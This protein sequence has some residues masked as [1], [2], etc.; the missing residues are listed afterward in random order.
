MKQFWQEN[1]GSISTLAITS[2]IA[3]L[4]I[5]F[6][7][8]NIGNIFAKKS[9]VEDTAKQLAPIILSRQ[10]APPDLNSPQTF[11]DGLQDDVGLTGADLPTI[12][13]GMLNQ[14]HPSLPDGFYP[15][16]NVNTGVSLDIDPQDPNFNS[17]TPND[18]NTQDFAVQVTINYNATP[19]GTL[20]SFSTI[21]IQETGRAATTFSDINFD[22]EN[23]DQCCCQQAE[24]LNPGYTTSNSWTGC[25]YAKEGSIF[26][27]RCFL[28]LTDLCNDYYDCRG[29]FFENLFS[30]QLFTSFLDQF[31]CW[32]PDFLDRIALIQD[33]IRSV[34]E[35]IWNG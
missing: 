12:V 34:G 7:S 6:L 28:G 17:I 2:I 33:T 22:P 31:D 19:L 18:Y 20:L 25:W 35:D 14:G 16:G 11:A 30:G 23:N 4:M 1:K 27:I 5:M 32:L 9:L 15:F 21:S 24:D 8:I 26:Y 3:V 29:R 10:L 13:F